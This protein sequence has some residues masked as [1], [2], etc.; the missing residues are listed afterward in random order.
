MHNL[1]TGVPLVVSAPS[2]GGKTTLCREVARRV[3]DV[4]FSISHTSRPP[5]PG[6]RD[7]VDYHFVNDATFRQLIDEGAFLEWARVHGNLYGTSS[8]QAQARLDAGNDVMFVIDVQGGRQILQRIPDAVSVFVVPPSLAV[9][10]E[11]LRGRQSDSPDQVELRLRVA[12]DEIRQATFYSHWLVNDD[13]DTAIENLASIL[14]AE[15]LKRL[16]KQAILHEILGSGTV[17]DGSH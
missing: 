8:I 2:G 10:E 15:R 11:R 16:N 4:N 1:R 5:R 3:G 13:L 17:S 7:G 6:E 14:R 9:L 12:G